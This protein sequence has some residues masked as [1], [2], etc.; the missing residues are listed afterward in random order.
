MVG[1]RSEIINN[2]VGDRAKQRTKGKAEYRTKA[3][4]RRKIR[5]LVTI[6]LLIIS[7]PLISSLKNSN[8]YKIFKNR[9]INSDLYNSMK[10]TSSRERVYSEAIKLNNG[11]SSNTCVYFIAE[12]LRMNGENVDYSVCNTSQLLS[13]MKKD[14][15]KKE[16]DYKKLKPGDIC[17]TTDEKLNKKGIPTHTYIFMG[18]RDENKYE[19]AYI[20]DNQAKDYKGKIYHLRNITI[21]ENVNGNQKEPFNFFLYR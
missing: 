9:N 12:A 15:W 10:D 5:F 13:L 11:S 4:K 2:K 17:F 18:W 14:G 20:C 1:N 21:T 16:Y 3:K 6:S 7:Y 19:Y 8:I